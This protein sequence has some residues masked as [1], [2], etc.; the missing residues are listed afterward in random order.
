MRMRNLLFVWLSCVG[1][2]LSTLG[3]AS[4]EDKKTGKTDAPEKSADAKANAKSDTKKDAK[5]DPKADKDASAKKPP[6]LMKDIMQMLKM[7]LTPDDIFAKAQEQGIDFELT[8]PIQGQLRKS[9][10][11]QEQIDALKARKGKD[12]QQQQPQ[13]QQA[14]LVA[15]QNL[16]TSED[17]RAAERER[18]EKITKLSTADAP[19]IEGAHI[20]LWAAKDLQAVYF[21]DVKTLEKFL[22][23]KFDEPIRSGLDKRAAHIVLIKTRYEYERWVKAMFEVMGDSINR[24]QNVSKEELLAQFIKTPGFVFPTFGV[25]CVENY[26]VP[27]LH[28]NVAADIGF[29]YFKQLSESPTTNSLCTGFANGTENVLAGSPSVMLFSNSY[30]N[31]NRDLG[32]AQLTWMQIVK[33]RIGTKEVTPVGE[34]LEMDTTKLLL[35]TYAEAWSLM[36]LLASQREKF[37]K[38]VLTIREQPN[39]LKAIEIAYGWDEKKLTEEWHKHVLSR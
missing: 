12:P 36:D 7:R 18:I 25:F 28:R 1:L 13:P 20:T 14:A 8:V 37:A 4:A 29:M 26:T 35:P 15:G 32:A 2:I 38:L 27:V 9:G 34:L 33:N 3:T 39:L 17:Q 6:L 24:P 5:S 22:E 30:S 31:P 19:P 16:R 11:T 23:T 10:F 21:P